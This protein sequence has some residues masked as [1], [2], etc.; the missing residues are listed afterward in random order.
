MEQSL[1]DF[2]FWCN[3]FASLPLHLSWHVMLGIGAAPSVL[4]SPPLVLA[5]TCAVFL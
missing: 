4:P 3:A 2:Q 1:T 5:T